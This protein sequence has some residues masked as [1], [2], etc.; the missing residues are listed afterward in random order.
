M[1]RAA[2]CR[3]PAKRRPPLRSATASP[4]RSR[5]ASPRSCWAS[6][7][8]RRSSG[9]TRSRRWPSRARGSSLRARPTPS[10]P[11]ASTD[12]ERGRDARL[13]AAA[14]VLAHCLA[15]VDA[16]GP[17]CVAVKPQLACF[18][19]LG[20]AGWLA[21]EATVAHAR[22][23]GLLV[24]ADGKRGDIASTATAY[25]A[26]AARRRAERRSAAVPGLG[27]DAID[28][29]TRCS[30]RDALEPLID[31][32]ARARR[33]RLRPRPHVEPR[34][35][36]PVRPRARRRRPAVGAARARWSPR[37]AR[38]GP[39]VG[40]RRRRRRHRRDRARSTSRACAS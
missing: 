11:P 24:I 4:P 29:S 3:T 36:R 34:R 28:A 5:R 32:R 27:A 20:F 18:E 19:R 22:A 23:Q 10:A 13:E 31:D 9:P 1:R 25:G 39:R 37:P 16:A 17:A 7:P 8:T 30:A 6:T 12:G 26:G 15:L 40:A 38:P 33:G 14:A 2:L 21:L 35:R